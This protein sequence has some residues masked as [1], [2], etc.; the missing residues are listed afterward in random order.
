MTQVV[1][2]P[3]YLKTQVPQYINARK[4]LSAHVVMSDVGSGS[5]EEVL[6]KELNLYRTSVTGSNT[7][8]EAK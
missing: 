3:A 2:T 6:A 5:G 4:L 7:S 1:Q 8:K